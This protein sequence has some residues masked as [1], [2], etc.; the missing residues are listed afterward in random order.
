MERLPRDILLIFYFDSGVNDIF[1]GF[2]W[3][4]TCNIRKYNR[5]KCISY[6]QRTCVSKY[7]YV[8]QIDYP[9]LSSLELCEFIY[10]ATSKLT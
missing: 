4:P 2:L 3:Y 7:I 5:A 10:V 8:V 6:M 1:G 9:R